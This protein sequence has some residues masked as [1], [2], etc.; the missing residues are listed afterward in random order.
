MYV[1]FACFNPIV[2]S[3]VLCIQLCY[4]YASLNLNTFEAVT[5]TII[6]HIN[7]DIASNTKVSSLTL[8]IHTSYILA[9]MN[10]LKLTS[11]ERYLQI[12]ILIQTTTYDNIRRS[13]NHLL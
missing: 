12:V 1:T 11:T 13:F 10:T 8:T 6:I 9:N 2:L 4:V 7:N 3:I 5:Y